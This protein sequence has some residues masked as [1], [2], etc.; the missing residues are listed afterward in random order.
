MWRGWTHETNKGLEVIM[1]YE[2][3]TVRDFTKIPPDR[4]EVC[5][6]EFK[7]WVALASGASAITGGRVVG[8]KF[9][10]ID[11]GKTSVTIDIHFKHGNH[12]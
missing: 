3:E 11:D 6:S 8:E 1:K 2:I 12:L 7:M 4:L 10:W 5:L 9:T